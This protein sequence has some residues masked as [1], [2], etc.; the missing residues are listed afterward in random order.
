MHVKV[1]R[2]N[3]DLVK[4]MEEVMIIES[5]LNYNKRGLDVDK[6]PAKYNGMCGWKVI[7]LRTING[8]IS[9]RGVILQRIDNKTFKNTP[10]LEK[11][12][13]ITQI[14]NELTPNGIE[15]VYLVRLMK[16]DH[17]GFITAHNDG[18][19]FRNIT[20]MI[21]THLPIVTHPEVKMKIEENEYFLEAGKL[22]LTRVDKMHSV[23]NNSDIDR[24]HLVI[25]FKPTS[26]MLESI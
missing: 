5:E 20:Q 22:W 15:D 21:R 7:G 10:I 8:D 23:K 18:P 14:L 26:A 3:Y 17:G 24:I 1:L 4:L 2:E 25:D 6:I 9:E 16:L 11:C 19:V 13:Y 12:P